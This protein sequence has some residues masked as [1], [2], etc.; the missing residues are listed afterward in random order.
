MYSPPAGTASGIP[1]A[2]YP[3]MGSSPVTNMQPRLA[4]PGQAQMRPG[5]PPNAPMQ[6]PA[7]GMPPGA[8]PGAPPGGMPAQGA[9]PQQLAQ[10]LANL[11]GGMR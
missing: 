8:P 7:G 5:M 3:V 10:G 4:N 2:S 11:Q 6:A 1:G 9:N